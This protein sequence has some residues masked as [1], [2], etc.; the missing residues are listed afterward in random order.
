MRFVVCTI[1]LKLGAE[2]E[3]ARLGR[4]VMSLDN[5]VPSFLSMED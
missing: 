5:S 1:N 4:F 2:S 3:T